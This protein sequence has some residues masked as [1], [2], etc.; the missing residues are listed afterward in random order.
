MVILCPYLLTPG[1]IVSGH[2]KAGT[3]SSFP[4]NPTNQHHHHQ[5]IICPEMH[6]GPRQTFPPTCD[7]ATGEAGL[8]GMEMFQGAGG[9][10]RKGE[11]EGKTASPPGPNTARHCHLPALP[12]PRTA[13]VLPS[14][15][16]F[17]ISLNQMAQSTS[18]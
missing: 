8:L 14:V 4:L 2:T 6:G 17:L 13:A 7:A 1:T 9:R 11:S 3:V 5:H 15:L 18:S 10:K 16:W 12:S